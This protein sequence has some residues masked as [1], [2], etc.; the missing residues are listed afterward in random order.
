MEPDG[1]K[2]ANGGR[3][4]AEERLG[5]R[6]VGIIGTYGQG[7]L[8]DEALFVA[9]TQWVG[10][11]APQIVPIALC[12]NPR[13]I[14][15]TY[16]VSAY[17]VSGR[18]AATRRSAETLGQGAASFAPE[19]QHTQS[20]GAGRR[21]IG[22]LRRTVARSMPAVAQWFRRVRRDVQGALAAARFLPRQVRMAR[23]LDAVIVLGGGQIHDFWDGPFGYPVTL[24]SW[25]LASRLTRRPFAI[26]SVGA[27]ELVHGMS[28]RLVR[29]TFRWSNPA[30][31][32][33]RGSAHEVADLGVAR[34]CPIY[35]D[36]AWGLD[37]AGFLGDPRGTAGQR[38]PAP[39]ECSSP[40]TVGV[41][42]MAY[43]HPQLW[44]A[45]DAEAY[46]RYVGTLAAF[47]D[48]LVSRGY[49]VVLFPTQI[50][51]DA[52]AARDVLERI[53]PDLT[54]HVRLWPVDGIAALVRCLSSVDVVVASRFHGVLL[55]L[56][57]GRPVLSL[58]YQHKCTALLEALG[59]GQFG[60]DLHDCSEQ[61]LWERFEQLAGQFS[62][63]AARLRSHAEENRRKLHAQY[64]SYFSTLWP[65][66]SA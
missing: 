35:P 24:F 8:G 43:R 58:G 38:H 59:E 15:Q 62:A 1:N 45:G 50:L 55:S 3:M 29:A 21:L 53:S 65:G 13:Y 2:V 16:G 32:R 17:P 57:A 4:S 51:S 5:T 20:R 18:Y 40:R 10:E 42:P 39:P 26:L 56:L 44:A 34:A 25:A 48:R 30:T 64:Q 22:R 31:V 63:Y 41:S 11:H 47:C 66:K 14:E 46:A 19:R 52:L 54:Q 33:D 27:V 61:A 28:R 37:P 7:N 23:A 49:D 9:F 12:V 6:R 60:L 36:L